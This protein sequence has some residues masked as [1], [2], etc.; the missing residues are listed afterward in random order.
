MDRSRFSEDEALACLASLPG[1]PAWV[2]ARDSVVPLLAR[3]RAQA[4]I[5]EPVSVHLDPGVSVSFAVDLGPLFLHVTGPLLRAWQVDVA[6]VA[7]QAIANLRARA[8]SLAPDSAVRARVGLTSLSVL[9]A[10]D[11]WASSL[12]LTPDLLPRWFGAGPRILIAP[13]RNLLAAL[14]PQTDGR[15]VRWLREE[16]AAQMSDALD[17]PALAWDGARLHCDEPATR[18]GRA[19]VGRAVA[20]RGRFPPRRWRPPLQGARTTWYTLPPER[21]VR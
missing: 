8:Q 10:P 9:Q 11:G 12:V 1:P 3:R 7:R 19:S 13:A 4:P 6:Q 5:G 21:S 16:L 20:A 17:V 2:H 14:P 15:L 18:P